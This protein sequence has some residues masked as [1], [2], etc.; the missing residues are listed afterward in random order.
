MYV[1]RVVKLGCN[2]LARSRSVRPGYATGTRKQVM[3]LGTAFQQEQR[4]WKQR[5]T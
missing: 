2:E 3:Q 1:W 4:D 5:L